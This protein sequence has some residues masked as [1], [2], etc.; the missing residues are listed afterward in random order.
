MNV[1]TAQLYDVLIEK[2]FDKA[3]V[4][5]ALSEIVTTQE[6]DDRLEGLDERIDR[7]FAEFEAK[8]YRSQLSTALAIVAAN[9]AGTAL[10][11]QFFQA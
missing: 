10:I 11:L 1:A 4:R 5:E 9:L 7:R 6:M 8:L 3:R 2:G